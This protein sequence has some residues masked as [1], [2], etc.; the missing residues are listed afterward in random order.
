MSSQNHGLTPLKTLTSF[1]NNPFLE[2]LQTRMAKEI[3]FRGENLA[4]L[5]TQRFRL[6]LVY[7]GLVFFQLDQAALIL[8]TRYF[9]KFYIV[10]F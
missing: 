10:S 3:L 7:I 1:M 5:S 2:V 6:D 4:G 8:L 9:K